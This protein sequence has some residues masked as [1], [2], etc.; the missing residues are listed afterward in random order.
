[1]TS[2]NANSKKQQE[3]YQ[4][5]T[6]FSL[7]SASNLNEVLIILKAF[8]IHRDIYMYAFY[9]ALEI[10]SKTVLSSYRKNIYEMLY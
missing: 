2:E 10:S 4:S 9:K 1:M 3:L 7:L 6:P 8:K 5:Q